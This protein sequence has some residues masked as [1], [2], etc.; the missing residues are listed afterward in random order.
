MVDRRLLAHW[1][2]ERAARERAR[3]SLPR[4]WRED[5]RPRMTEVRETFVEGIVDLRRTVVLIDEDR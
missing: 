4:E 5:E 2:R 3:A 1:K